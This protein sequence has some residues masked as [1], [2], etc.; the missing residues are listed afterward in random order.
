MLRL[1][2]N[3]V[4][5]AMIANLQKYLPELAVYDFVP[6]SANLPYVTIGNMVTN[7][8][9]TKTEDR[10]KV[11]M[12]I[13][14][15]SNYHGK[16]QVNHIAQQIINVLQ[17]QETAELDLTADN[18]KLEA[19]AVNMYEAYPED[20]SGY[21]GVINAEMRI[22]NTENKTAAAKTKSKTTEANEVKENEVKESNESEE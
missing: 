6:Q 12:Q 3:A 18:F 10:Y 7:D 14:I 22:V 1:P 20:Q 8:I 16:Y 21:N 5:K 15:W 19:I 9:S 2:N 13:N 11:D 4:Q 17:N